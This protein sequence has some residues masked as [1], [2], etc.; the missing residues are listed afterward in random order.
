MTLGRDHRGSPFARPNFIKL[1]VQ[2]YEIE[3]LREECAHWNQP[4]LF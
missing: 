2:G 1:D 4:K 3:V